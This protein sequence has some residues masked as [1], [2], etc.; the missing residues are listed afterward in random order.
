M[1][2]EWEHKHPGRLDVMFK[3]LL[4]VAPSHLGDTSLFDFK[5]LEQRRV[6]TPPVS[7]S[8]FE[9]IDVLELN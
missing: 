2:N 8:R 5:N 6:T 1:L 7:D 4:N 9:R 3:S